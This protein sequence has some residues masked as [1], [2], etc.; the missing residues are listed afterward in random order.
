MFEKCANLAGIVERL[1]ELDERLTIEEELLM[2]GTN[3]PVALSTEESKH[4]PA[5]IQFTSL[6]ITTPT[7]VTLAKN[8]HLNIHAG[9]NQK[10]VGLNARRLMVTGPNASGKTAFFRILAGLWPCP[11]NSSITTCGKIQF[12]AQRPYMV[13]GTLLNQVLYP[14]SLAAP[15]SASSETETDAETDAEKT[16][17][18][19]I[20]HEAHELLKVAGIDYLVER[21]K[22]KGGWYAI[23]KWEKTLSL[24]E[25]QRLCM[26]RM[27]HKKPDIA[28]LDECTDAVSI[29]VER[30]LYAAA[31]ERGL[32][33][34]TIS[35]RLALEEFHEVELRLGE[36]NEDGYRLLNV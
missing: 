5:S 25:Q 21:W 28:V 17:R 34:V 20:E 2:N 13:T 19:D 18:E 16:T 6:N 32:T 12:V 36:N 10:N 30:R 22:E 31:I 1:A 8:I 26:A 9:K 33:C 3:K 7:H 35:K 24:G 15:S 27:L 4:Q 14:Q 11:A 23:A 29:D